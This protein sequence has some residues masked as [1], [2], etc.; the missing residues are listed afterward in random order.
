VVTGDVTVTVG[1]EVT[2]LG[3]LCWELAWFGAVADV[4][5]ELD[6]LELDVLEE[7]PEGAVDPL[8][9]GV[10]P[11]AAPGELPEG[12]LPEAGAEEVVVVAAGDPVVDVSVALTGLGATPAV[13]CVVADEID[14]AGVVDVEAVDVS[15]GAGVSVVGGA[16]VVSVV[17]EV[18]DG[19]VEV[20]VGGGWEMTS[21]STCV[22][23]ALECA[24]T[25]ARRWRG[26]VV[27]T[28]ADG[29][30]RAA[31]AVARYEPEGVTVTV[32][33]PLGFVTVVV[34]VPVWLVVAVGTGAA[35]AGSGTTGAGAGV[36]AAGTTGVTG[37]TVGA[38]GSCA[39]DAPTTSVMTGA[40]ASGSLAVLEAPGMVPTV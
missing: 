19:E 38:L 8:G 29:D 4:M 21:R 28:W 23:A 15:A 18:E 32:V 2:W 20:V 17:V 24:R 31:L 27:A 33:E 26:W 3:L 9:G 34:V 7:L 16:V 30:R 12:E 11:G 6:V 37:G 35:G 5:V 25:G 13:P 40:E 36:G 10:E 39:P 22:I 14:E 1:A